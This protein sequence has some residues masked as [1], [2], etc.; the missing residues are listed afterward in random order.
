MH[1]LARNVDFV[2][3]IVPDINL[4]LFSVHIRNHHQYPCLIKVAAKVQGVWQ[5]HGLLKETN[6]SVFLSFLFLPTVCVTEYDGVN[7]STQ[8][9]YSWHARRISFH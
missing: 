8:C 1:R 7:Y 2:G 3:E 6:L 9:T 4:T 5:H